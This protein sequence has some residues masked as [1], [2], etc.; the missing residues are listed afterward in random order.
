MTAP[1]VNP[2]GLEL[3]GALLRAARAGLDLS[4]QALA[5]ATGLGV[6]T[7]RR[8]ER[9]GTGGMSKVNRRVLIETLIA[10]GARFDLRDGEVWLGFVGDDAHTL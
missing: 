4:A 1:A 8:S 5:D 10:R 2:A 7:I 9:S 3:S 6:N